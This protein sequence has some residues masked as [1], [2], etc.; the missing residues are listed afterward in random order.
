MVYNVTVDGKHYRLDLSCKDGNWLCHLDG[1]EIEVDPVLLRQNVLSLIIGGVSY[2]VKRELTASDTH[3]WIGGARYQTEL[4]DPRSLRSYRAESGAAAGK[5]KIIAPM[6][7]KVVRVLVKEKM[8]VQAGQGVVVV[9][10]MKMQN[11]L[12]S[13]K[14]GIVQKVMVAEGASVKAGDVLLIVE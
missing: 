5:K 4:H 6:P 8:E 14:Q 1:R 11:E 9:E 2:E 3:L 13:P 12:K 7:G 10:A